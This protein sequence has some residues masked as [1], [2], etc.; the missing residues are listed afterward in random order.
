M[1][2]RQGYWIKKLFVTGKERTSLQ[3]HKKREEIWVVLRGKVRVHIG[4][5]TKVLA[6][7]AFCHVP[8][9]SKHRITGIAPESVLL[10]VALGNPL[11]GDIVRYE[12]DYGR[13]E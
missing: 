5:E 9:K 8:K 10:E 1:E 6:V 2:K 7:G 3:S 11:E 12:D 4:A 13:T